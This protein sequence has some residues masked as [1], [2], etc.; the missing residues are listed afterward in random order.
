M[1]IYYSHHIKKRATSFNIISR[2]RSIL[3]RFAWV[4]GKCAGK[5]HVIRHFLSFRAVTK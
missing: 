1:K 2:R 4:R 3:C 5:D